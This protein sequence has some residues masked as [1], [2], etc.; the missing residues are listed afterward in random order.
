MSLNPEILR[1]ILAVM[2]IAR[3]REDLTAWVEDHLRPAEIHETFREKALN[4]ARALWKTLPRQEA[5]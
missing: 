1:L 5:S 2:R 3:T 4:E